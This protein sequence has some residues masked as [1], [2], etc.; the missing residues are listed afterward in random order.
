[1]AQ[2]QRP[3]YVFMNGRLVAWEDATLHIGSEAF[4]RGM[5]VF[6]G[7]KA[8]W[9]H[10]NKTLGILALREHHARLSRSALLQHLPFSTSF[11]ELRD[12]CFLLLGKLMTPERD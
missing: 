1:M 12:A 11:E 7:I 4:T 10:D 3:P 5:S 8:Y 2:L 6:E 9:S